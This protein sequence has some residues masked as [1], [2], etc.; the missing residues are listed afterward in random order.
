MKELTERQKELLETPIINLPLS[1]ALKEHFKSILGE[2]K[3]KDF[4][5]IE[6]QAKFN[7]REIE[8][9]LIPNNGNSTRKDAYEN[10]RN[11]LLYCQFI[12]YLIDHGFECVSEKEIMK[13][14]SVLYEPIKKLPLS[15]GLQELLRKKYKDRYEC[16]TLEAICFSYEYD[17]CTLEKIKSII[18]DGA[19]NKIEEN[20]R[21]KYYKELAE[22]LRSKKIKIY[23]D[24]QQKK[25]E[26]KIGK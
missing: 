12:N 26:F 24:E 23:E 17:C 15:T 1:E 6:I 3:L 16:L 14:R 21:S 5:Y 2:K 8:R 19:Q 22:Y 18:F 25:L 9:Q 13:K 20:Q 10:I 4:C 7:R 11:N